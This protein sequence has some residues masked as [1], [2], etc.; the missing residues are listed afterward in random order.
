MLVVYA[1]AYTVRPAFTDEI[2]RK[3]FIPGLTVRIFGALTVGFIYQFYYNG[4]DTFAY[5]THGSR[6]IWE[7]FMHDPG[8]GFQLL[9]SDGTHLPSTFEYSSKIW[10]FRDQQS[11]A[12]IRLATVLDMLTFS[13]YSGTAVLFAVMSFIGSW[14]LFRTFYSTYPEAHVYLAFSCFFIPSV[15]FWGS[16]I[17]KDTVTLTALSVATYFLHK[18]IVHRHISW[19]SVLAIV[20]AL[21]VIYSIKIYILLCFLPAAIVW[22][23]SHQL[24]YVRS[25]VMKI[26]LIPLVIVAVLVLGYSA[27][28]K[29]AED[30]P[31]YNLERIAETAR[32]TAYDIRYWTGKDAGSGYSLGELDGSF[33]SL[34]RHAP[35]A[36][37]VTLFRPYLWEVESPLMM[38]SA[39][40]ALMYLFLT[41]AVI[42]GSGVRII[43]YASQPDIVFCLLFSIGFSFAVGVSTFN[44]GTLS[45]YKIPALPY[46]G[47]A[48]TLVYSY[49]R[50]HKHSDYREDDIALK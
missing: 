2:T 18:I 17:F 26:L 5:H 23:F 8:K 13:S 22:I 11:F 49:S 39:L 7:A 14:L 10:F 37:V 47:I 34:I 43:R 24:S 48:L 29:V 27:V 41:V 15:F 36:I 25:L 40:E 16:G 38:L 45:R 20:L 46:Y 31:K 12:V 19:I 1:V 33:E 30:N 4:G 32:V 3:Y 44:F 28:Q 21:W 50:L 9:L 35:Q 6:I 42:V